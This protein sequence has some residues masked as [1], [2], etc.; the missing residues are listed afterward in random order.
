MIVQH[1]R[2][3]LCL[4]IVAPTL[5]QYPTFESMVH[6]RTVRAQRWDVANGKRFTLDIRP[7][8]KEIGGGRTIK[9]EVEGNKAQGT[10]LRRLCEL[11]RA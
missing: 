3:C 5:H 6:G 7:R 8:F 9:E 4:Y 11:T 2:P 10:S 1:F